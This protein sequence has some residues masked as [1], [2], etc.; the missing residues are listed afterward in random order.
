MIGSIGD[1]SYITVAK[2]PLPTR[3]TYPDLGIPGHM[4]I[5]PLVHAPTLSAI[6]DVDAAEKTKTEM[7]KYQDSIREMLISTSKDDH[8]NSKLG[9]VT[10]EI[11]RAG[12][13]H[14]HWQILPV[15]VELLQDGSVEAAFKADAEALHY[16]AFESATEKLPDVEAGNCFRV[17]IWSQ[18][19]TKR[20]ALPLDES[21][22]FD[23]Q[24]GR[25]V[26]GKLLGLSN[27][28]NWKDCGQSKLD[29]EADTAVFKKLFKEHDFTLKE[30]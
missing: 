10:W 25:R 3:N 11:S 4:L 17:E 22:S 19:L 13:I 16:P 15:P 29:E 21:F 18:A 14:N 1:E 27:R 26:M 20:L 28:T 5:I 9:T 7:L 8:G 2:G 6:P 12:G 24:F 30:E 23:L